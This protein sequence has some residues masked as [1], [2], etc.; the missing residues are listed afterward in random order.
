LGASVPPERR[1]LAGTWVPRRLAR[2]MPGGAPLLT[3]MLWH[4]CGCWASLVASTDCN[5]A[6]AWP[7]G[8]TTISNQVFVWLPRS[9]LGAGSD[10]LAPRGR[11]ATSRPKL[12]DVTLERQDLLPRWSVG[13]RAAAR[14]MTRGET[15]RIPVPARCRRSKE[16]PRLGAPASGRQWDKRHPAAC[17]EQG[18]AALAVSLR[19]QWGIGVRL[20]FSPIL[21]WGCWPWS[22]SSR[23]DGCSPTN[24]PRGSTTAATGPSGGWRPRS[25]LAP[26]LQ[27]GSR[28]R[29]SGAPRANCHVEAQVE[30]RDAGASGLAPTLERGSQ[31]SVGAR[32]SQ[33]SQSVALRAP[34]PAPASPMLSP[35]RSPPRSARHLPHV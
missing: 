25:R 30:G 31:S 34:Q 1:H 12:K 19:P 23:A 5:A 8:A 10:A 7:L 14:D 13:A 3:P 26:K 21:V 22:S 24:S 20:L 35:S 4:T 6:L 27:P 9:S 32:A 15:P 29:R 16:R 2:G 17:G 11:I 28:Q 18:A 33:H